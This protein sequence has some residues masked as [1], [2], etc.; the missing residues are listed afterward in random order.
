[1]A[2][3]YLIMV[4]PLLPWKRSKTGKMLDIAH[5][6][7]RFIYHIQ[8]DEASCQPLYMPGLSFPN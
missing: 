6:S 5:P 4:D 1:M 2:R 3:K 8:I 7:L